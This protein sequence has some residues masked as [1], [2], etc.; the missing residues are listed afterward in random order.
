[1]SDTPHRLWQ[2]IVL[3]AQNAVPERNTDRDPDR[4]PDQLPDVASRIAARSLAKRGMDYTDEVRRLLDAALEV[5]GANGTGSR[6]RVADIVAAAGLSNEAFY[7]HFPA[8][9]ALVAALLEDGSDRLAGYAAHQMGKETEPEG[10]IRRWVAAVMSQTEQ[11]Q[12]ATTLAVLWNGSSVGT[13]MS[14]GRHNASIP[15]AA[16]LVEPLTALGA[17]DAELVASLLAHAVIGKMSDFLWSARRPTRREMDRITQLC[18]AAA[19]GG[20]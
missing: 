15:L 8:K 4:T 7:R 1:M 3:M 19:R 14:A 5:M 17:T 2:N 9:D 12:A 18:L 11:P 10:R 20:P 13:G 16:L 6:A